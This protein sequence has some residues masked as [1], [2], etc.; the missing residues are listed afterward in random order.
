MKINKYLH[1]EKNTGV[2]GF[3]IFI[4]ANQSAH[5]AIGHIEE[6]HQREARDLSRSIDRGQNYVEYHAFWR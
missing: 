1:S 5:K 4:L 3:R 6:P 2:G